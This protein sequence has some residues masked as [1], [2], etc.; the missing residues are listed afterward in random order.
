MPERDRELGVVNVTTDESGNLFDWRQ[1][2]GDLF[3]VESSNTR[4]DKAY[5]AVQYRDAWFYIR[6]N[7]VVSK[8]TFVLFQM[9]LALRAGEIPESR[10]PVT[11]PVR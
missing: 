2:T 3:V 4:P 9:V 10:T 6:D 5:V 8:D 11:L 7:D 1:V